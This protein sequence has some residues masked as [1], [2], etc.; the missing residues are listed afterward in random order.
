MDMRQVTCRSCGSNVDP[1]DWIFHFGV[2]EGILNTRL[3]SLK[4]EIAKLEKKRALLMKVVRA[5]KSLSVEQQII[6]QKKKGNNI[7]NIVGKWPGDEP[8]ED[9]T[10]E[11]D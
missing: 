11:L 1:F 8:A 9:I 5:A 10:S 7:K 4:D 3:I 2:R 6:N